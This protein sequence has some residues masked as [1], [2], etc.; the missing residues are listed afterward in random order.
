M[1]LDE[2]VAVLSQTPTPRADRVL[3]VAGLHDRVD[4]VGVQPEFAGLSV[5]DGGLDVPAADRHHEEI[6]FPPLSRSS[7]L[8]RGPV[9]LK[10]AASMALLAFYPP[11]R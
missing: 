7:A 3:A 10:S 5:T 2:I 8:V 4:M 6:L 11:L 9:N 1:P